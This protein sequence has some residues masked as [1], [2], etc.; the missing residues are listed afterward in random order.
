MVDKQLKYLTV[1]Y[2]QN[3][4]ENCDKVHDS[5]YLDTLA[6]DTDLDLERDPETDRSKD[7]LHVRKI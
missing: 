2:K 3:K 7:L 4:K 1:V 6:G 5:I